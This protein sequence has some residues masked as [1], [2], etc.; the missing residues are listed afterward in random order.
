MEAATA[1]SVQ[2]IKSIQ[3]TI[4]DM[5]KITAAIASAVSEQSAATKEIARG[6]DMAFEGTAQSAEEVARIQESVDST[7]NN[8]ETLKSVAANLRAVAGRVRQQVNGLG[9]RLRAA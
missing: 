4:N 2:T 9:E 8:A 5:S 6:A 1:R 3:G 7:L